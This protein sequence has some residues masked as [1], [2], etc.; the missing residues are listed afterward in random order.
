VRWPAHIQPGR[1][2]AQ[3]T[4]LTDLMATCAAVVGAELPHDAAEDSFNMLPEWLAAQQLEPIRP[5]LLQQTISLDLSIRQGPWKL[6]DHQG[7][8][9]NNYERHPQLRPYRLPERAPEAPGQLYKLDEDPGETMNVYE[10]HPDVVTRLRQ[11]LELTRQ[12][13]RSRDL[14][15]P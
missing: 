5:F 7:S 9:G 15:S 6:L 12:Q 10:Q 8:G 4:S 11:L 14:G 13:G 1:T 3:L 2:T